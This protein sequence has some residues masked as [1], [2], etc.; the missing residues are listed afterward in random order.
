MHGICGEVE[1]PDGDNEMYRICHSCATKKKAQTSPPLSNPT[2]RK[3]VEGG[4]PAPRTRKKS[5]PAAAARGA[6]TGLN[7]GQKL[8]VLKLLDQEVAH[9]EIARRFNCGTTAIGTIRKNRATLLADAAASSRSASSM[10][11]KGGDFPKVCE[12]RVGVF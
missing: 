10:S 8:E 7:F 5:T 9:P 11:S 2:K 6:R 4:F 1:D 12:S 3:K